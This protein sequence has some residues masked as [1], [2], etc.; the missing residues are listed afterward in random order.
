MI[1]DVFQHLQK[2]G[3]KI[4]LSNFFSA[5]FFKRADSLSRSPS[6]WKFHSPTNRQYRSINE[7]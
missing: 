1:K 3:P 2:A 7:S 5:H 4:K 6:K